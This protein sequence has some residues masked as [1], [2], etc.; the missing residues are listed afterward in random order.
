[1]PGAERRA[2]LEAA[3]ARRGSDRGRR[4]DDFS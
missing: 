1:V 2:L 3:I 4:E